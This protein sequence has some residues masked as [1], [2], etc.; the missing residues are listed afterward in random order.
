[1]EHPNIIGVLGGGLMGSGIAALFAAAGHSVRLHEPH[2]PA[3]EQLPARMAEA[4]DVLSAGHAISRIQ[5][6]ASLHEAA[7]AD[8]VFEAAPEEIGLKRAIFAELVDTSPRHTILASNTSVIP[9]GTI[10]RGLPTAERI[11]GTHFWNPPQ[12]IPLVEVVQAEATSLATVE[13]SMRLL[14]GAGKRP[15]HV[16]KDVPGFIANRLQHAMWRE[17]IAMVADGVCDARTLDE[18]VKNSFGLRLSVLGPLENADLV[19]LDL[20]LAIH[21]TIMP[22]L[23]RHDHPHPFLADHVARG[24]LG[25]KTGQG[26]RAWTPEEVRALRT[27]LTNHL[28]SAL[29]VRSGRSTP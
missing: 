13:A 28:K 19:G 15:A 11:V 12:L 6:V 8:F 21:R 3:R 25:C 24:E 4:L 1:M 5:L 27:D 16:R 10:A 14:A 7:Q 18:C 2:A 23:D 17:A 22:E 9:I 29:A 20:T 26:F